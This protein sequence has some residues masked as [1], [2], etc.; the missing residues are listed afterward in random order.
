MGG[1]LMQLVAY[2]AQDVY[3]SGNPQITFFKVVYRRHT[4]FA[5]EPIPQTW[6]G[7][8]DFGRTVTCNINRNGDLVTHM[9]LY[10]ALTNTTGTSGVM[11]GNTPVSWGYVRRL[12]HAICQMYKIEIGG[13]LID[14]QYGD[15]LNIWY[16]LTHKSGQERG[17]AQM[18]GDTDYMRK[19]NNAGKTASVLYVPF[20]FWFNRNNG[21]A[22][23]LIALQYHDVRI[24]CQLRDRMGCVN[25]LGPSN[26]SNKFASNNGMDDCNLL[27]DYVYLDS[28]ER[29][30][31]A[32]A[33]HEYLI[34]QLQFTGSEALT[35]NAKY[36]LNFNHPC[37]YLVWAPHFQ[38]YNTG[39]QWLAYATDGDWKTA[40]DRFAKYLAMACT[41]GLVVPA[42]SAS[43]SSIQSIGFTPTVTTDDLLPNSA[44][45]QGGTTAGEIVDLANISNGQYGNV[46]IAT[47]LNL[48]SATG[49]NT[50]ILY[51]LLS[52]I[53]VKAI[54]QGAPNT[55]GLTGSAAPVATS[56]ISWVDLLQQ[57]ERN[58]IVTRNELTMEDISLTV[59]DLMNLIES[60][61]LAGPNSAVVDADTLLQQ[62]GILAVDYFNYGNM[63]D[64]S[65]N[66]LYTGKLQLNGHDRFQDRDGNYFNYVQPYQHWSNTPADGI[67]SYSFAL[68]PEDHQP[69]GTCN[70]SRIDN[71][72]LLV[73]VGLYNKAYSS[74]NSSDA[75]AFRQRS[76][77]L[78][79]GASSQL[80]IYTMNY[81]VLRVMSGMAGTAYSN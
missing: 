23:P 1:G 32:Q 46:A 36:R 25:I 13:S 18:I 15:W 7:V 40:K 5:V 57:F 60:A 59:T 6:N 69:T 26:A 2:G 29:K 49:G 56:T 3:L 41:G 66:P 17:Y 22:L 47:K 43:F 72:T 78:T 63:V 62:A 61:N 55:G 70:F 65:D 14:Q 20:Q 50:Q 71:A 52:K 12:G 37:K 28:E 76:G 67:N 21:L 38:R 44:A 77:L 74:V 45:V 51:S 48:G 64:G 19:V 42:A 35:A 34:E 10:V 68:K 39:A 75:N 31:F 9:Y 8:G 16:E 79:N 27:I 81:N 30:R 58:T 11:N 33:S 24:T 54:L 73:D 4:N 80:N 53:D